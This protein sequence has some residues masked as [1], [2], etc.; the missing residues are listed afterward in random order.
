MRAAL[1]VLALVA[2]VVAAPAGQTSDS[3]TIS[4]S[5]GL[6]TPVRGTPLPVK[7]YQPRA[8]TAHDTPTTPEIKNVI[9]YLK[10]VASK[11]PVPASP[12]VVRQEHE[13]FVPVCSR[14]LEG[15]A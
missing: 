1:A 14:S 9:V 7:A 5:L 3:S 6:T 13:G 12:E 4:G 10:D 2:L 15:P 11:G 8:V